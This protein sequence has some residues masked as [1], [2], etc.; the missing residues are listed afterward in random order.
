[1]F[2]LRLLRPIISLSKATINFLGFRCEFCLR[3]VGVQLSSIIFRHF[4]AKS[5]WGKLEPNFPQAGF[6]LQYKKIDGNFCIVLGI[7]SWTHFFKKLRWMAW[8]GCALARRI[9]YKLAR[10]IIFYLTGTLEKHLKY[11]VLFFCYFLFFEV[12]QL[13][14]P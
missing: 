5:A 8:W 9:C 2:L 10:T 3:K 13:F 6:A 1:M 11:Q 4:N 12:F 7:H 14:T